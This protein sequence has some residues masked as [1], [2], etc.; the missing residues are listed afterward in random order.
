M[1]VLIVEDEDAAG[2]RLNKLIHNIDSSIDIIDIIDSVESA[3]I[4]F[5][6]KPSP[7][8]LFLDIQLADGLSFEIFDEVDVMCPVIFT[9]AY[10]KYALK[11][12]DLNSVDYL[13]K[14]IDQEKLADSIQKYKDVKDHY[15]ESGQKQLSDLV[16]TFNQMDKK[17]KLRFLINKADELIPIHVDDIA[18]FYAEEKLVFLVCNNTK[19]HI[20]NYTL[21]QLENMLDHVKFFRINRKQIISL[22]NISKIHMYF[23]YKLKLE[24]K[25]GL[26]QEFVVSKAKV[27]EFKKWLV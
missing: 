8:L 17:Y 19:R 9:T 13:L 2:K 26:T 20:I 15:T 23:N 25:T 24:V 1:R 4:F 18:F 27:N 10:D 11:A 21:E 16:S 14:P 5:K 6:T 7:D 22:D 3:I 12:F